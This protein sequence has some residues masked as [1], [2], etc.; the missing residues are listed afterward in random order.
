MRAHKRVMVSVVLAMVA[1]CGGI[2]AGSAPAPRVAATDSTPASMLDRSE[3]SR[4]AMAP[5]KK[6]G[7][8]KWK[9]AKGIG[10]SGGPAGRE[11]LRPGKSP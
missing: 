7:P 2:R 6:R 3:R 9:T 5:A 11:D 10:A 4:A 1:G 8:M